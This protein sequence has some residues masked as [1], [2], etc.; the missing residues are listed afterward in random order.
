MM[1]PDCHRR[2][3]KAHQDLQNLIEEL[4]PDFGEAPEMEAAK[5]VLNEAQDHLKAE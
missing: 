2:L 5:T 4:E 3:E 1:I